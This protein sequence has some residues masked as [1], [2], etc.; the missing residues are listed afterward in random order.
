[1]ADATISELATVVGVAVEKLLSQVKEA[2]LPHTKADDVISNEDKDTLLQ[3]LRSSH[4][5]REEAIAPR[6]ITLNR[7]TV[8]T[9]KAASG[10]GRG[11]T[12]NVEVRKKRTYVKRSEVEEEAPE[13][14]AQ[15]NVTEEA[16]QQETEVAVAPDAGQSAAE[17]PREDVPVE[18]NKKRNVEPEKAAPNRRPWK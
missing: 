3:F 2:G 16:K 6:K 14:S 1:M 11:K 8:G 5:E 4:G 9:L 15:E 12:V 10:H 17:T 18:S 7:K 13:G